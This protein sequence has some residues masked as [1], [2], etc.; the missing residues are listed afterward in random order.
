MYRTLLNKIRPLNKLGVRNKSEP[1][2]NIEQLEQ[3]TGAVDIIDD[4]SRI[5]EE[6]IQRKRNKSRLKVYHRNVVHEDVPYSE[7]GLSIHGTLKFNRNMYGRYGSKSGF[8]ESLCWPTKQELQDKIEY[9]SIAFPYNIKDV[10]EEAKKN[11]LDKQKKIE[12]H[13]ADIVKKIQ[14]L[15][16]WKEDLR[17]KIEK[18]EATVSAAKA[19]RDRLV[20]EVRR[21]FGYTVDPRDEKFKELLEKKEKEQKKAMKQARKKVQEEKMLAIILNKKADTPK[22]DN[23]DSDVEN[24]ENA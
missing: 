15:D 12:E 23:L 1:S 9:E 13:Q 19:Q 5:R 24:K 2:L 18:K 8:N 10:A 17:K 16:Q 21:H 7:P 6:D 22:K 3:Q 14:K 11:R 4:E 20:E